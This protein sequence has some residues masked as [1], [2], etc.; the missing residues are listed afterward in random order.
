MP[1]APRRTDIVATRWGTRFLGRRFPST[2]GRSGTTRHK[3]EGD[4]ATPVGSHRIVAI[5]FR[6]DRVAAH[7][8][9]RRAIP[10]GPGDLWSDDPR[11]TNYNQP[12]RAPHRFGHEHLRRADPIHDLV[13]VTNWNRPDAIPGNGSAIFIHQ[14]RRPH[15]PTAGCLALR[16]KDLRWIVAHLSRQTRLIVKP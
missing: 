3:R 2:I 12:V 14:W 10:I 16:R 15:A 13:L 8:L 6:P 7:R 1:A 4:G 11:D 9:P 5:H